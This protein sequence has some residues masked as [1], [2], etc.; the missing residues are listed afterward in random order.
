MPNCFTVLQAPEYFAGVSFYAQ[1]TFGV[2]QT[3]CRCRCIGAFFIFDK[4]DFKL[5]LSVNRMT[6]RHVHLNWRRTEGGSSGEL[7]KWARVAGLAASNAVLPWALNVVMAS[8]WLWSTGCLFWIMSSWAWT[9]EVWVNQNE[10]KGLGIIQSA[11]KVSS[12]ECTERLSPQMF[13]PNR[14]VHVLKA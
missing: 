13:S 8:W 6:Q 2:T 9:V 5:S 7:I 3:Q 4:P 11:K 12:R 10:I 14:E 1:H